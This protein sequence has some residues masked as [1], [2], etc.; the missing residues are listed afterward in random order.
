MY[1]DAYSFPESVGV[2][3]VVQ[4]YQF[5][6]HNMEGDTVGT[7]SYGGIG[8]MGSLVLLRSLDPGNLKNVIYSA[9]P[10]TLVPIEGSY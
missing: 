1:R 2:E 9:H 3:M 8:V 4:H 5:G 7:G 10:S 6:F